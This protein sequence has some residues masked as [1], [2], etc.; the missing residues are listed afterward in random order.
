[1]DFG[2]IKS[3]FKFNLVCRCIVYTLISWI[4]S[5]EKLGFLTLEKLGK[6]LRFLKLKQIDLI[7]TQFGQL[8]WIRVCLNGENWKWMLVGKGP[9]LDSLTMVH[10]KDQTWNFATPI[11]VRPIGDE[12]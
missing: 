7:E 3:V 1:M 12:N 8:E 2:E 10:L 11:G 5:F 9:I 4:E 6:N